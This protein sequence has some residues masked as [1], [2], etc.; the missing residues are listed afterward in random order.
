[1]MLVGKPPNQASGVTKY[2]ANISV[3]GIGGGMVI[4][5][6]SDC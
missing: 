6:L 1:M 4:V 2:V 5:L 3:P